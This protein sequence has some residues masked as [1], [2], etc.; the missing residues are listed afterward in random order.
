MEF[1]AP[2]NALPV[3]G[4]LNV[5]K[6][7]AFLFCLIFARSLYIIYSALHMIPKV[8]DVGWRRTTKEHVQHT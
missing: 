7:S 8:A 2:E 1:S 3:F 5:K 6:V 4:Y